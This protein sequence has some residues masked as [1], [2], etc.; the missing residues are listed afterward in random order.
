MSGDHSTGT[1]SPEEPSDDDD[2]Q[3]CPRQ[4]RDA[5]PIH[6]QI[7]YAELHSCTAEATTLIGQKPLL[8]PTKR[9]QND[10]R[11]TSNKRARPRFALTTT[12]VGQTLPTCALHAFACHTNGCSDSHVPTCSTPPCAEPHTIIDSLVPNTEPHRVCQD[13]L[14]ATV[15]LLHRSRP[16][17]NVL[18]PPFAIELFCKPRQDAHELRADDEHNLEIA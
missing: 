11:R 9:Q 12:C 6:N 1:T 4:P 14:R 18:A 5:I 2:K 17:T 16:T 8:C 7:Q 15:C 3:Q 10:G 13:L